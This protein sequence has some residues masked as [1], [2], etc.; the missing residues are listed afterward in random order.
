[1][2]SI[3]DV[4]VEA[5]K[6][7]ARVLGETNFLFTPQV[8]D[9]YPKVSCKDKIAIT[10]NPDNCYVKLVSDIGQARLFTN[11]FSTITIL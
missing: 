4:S 11:E 2:I 3:N 8:G 10:F 7:V 9:L 6:S 5:M 1:M